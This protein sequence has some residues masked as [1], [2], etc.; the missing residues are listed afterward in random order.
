MSALA[1]IPD[2]W[3]TDFGADTEP[4]PSSILRQQGYKLGERTNQVVYGEVESLASVNGWFEHTMYLAAPYLKAR[5]RIVTVTHQTQLY[6]ARV[7]AEPVGNFE[8]HTASELTTRLKVIFASPQIVDLIR[9][10]LAQARDLDA[11]E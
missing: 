9:S 5:Q 11:D 1:A 4:S 3:P 7:S 10:L 2:L 8:V 6:P